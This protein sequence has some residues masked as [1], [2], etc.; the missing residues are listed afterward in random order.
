MAV[1][2]RGVDCRRTPLAL[3]RLLL[4]HVFLV[5]TAM[6][7]RKVV[8]CLR[9]PH[10]VLSLFALANGATRHCTLTLVAGLC[11]DVGRRSLLGLGSHCIDWQLVLLPPAVLPQAKLFARP[12]AQRE[13]L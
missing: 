4:T 13:L 9:V 12:L 1:E 2:R 11:S 5:L 7:D 3:H 8:P 6:R 10:L